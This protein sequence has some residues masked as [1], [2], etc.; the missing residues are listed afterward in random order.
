MPPQP[1]PDAPL[2]AAVPA[3]T[4]GT[5]P[6]LLGWAGD[7]G[8]WALATLDAQGRFS[9]LNEEA[10]RVLG[11]QAGELLGRG[12]WRLFA[13]T[14]RP[15]I[16][17][18]V[19]AA[20]AQR[21]PL[22]L[23]E[24]DER[25][26]RWLELRGQPFGAGLALHLRDVTTRRRSQEQLR[27][28]EGSISR[29]NDIV[30]IT[31]ASPFNEPG[32]RIV[33]VNE[34]FE[35]RTGYSREEALGRSPRFLQG[36]R[37][38]RDRLDQV[39]R[40]LEQWQPVRVD[41]VNYRKDGEPFWVDL[42]IS[43]VWDAARK[44][45]HW[46]A[47]GRDVSE[48]KAAEQKI[49]YLAFFDPLTGL[50]NRQQLMD[51]LQ[52]AAGP[53]GRAR[54]GA[55]MFIDL[56]NFKV[57]NDTL[58]H[59][60]GDL[61]LKEV[62]RRLGDCV[63]DDGLVARLG[64]DEFVVLLQPPA[65]D[66]QAAAAVA[67]GAARALAE[68][69]LAA[70]GEPYPLP[71]YLHHSTC[72]IGVTVFGPQPGPVSELLKQADLAMYQAKRAG[73]NTA[74]FFDPQMQAVASAHA[75]LAA[76]LR[77][78]CRE[79]RFHLD[80]QPQVDAR[81]YLRGVEALLRWDHPQRGCVPPERFIP[82]AEETS[83]ILDIG[84]QVLDAACAQ[85]ARWARRP[86]RE[87]LTVAVNVS[88][89]QFRHPE[90]VDGVM[91]AIARAGIAPHRLKLELTETLLADGFEV[92]VARMGELRSRGVALSLD[93]FG[94]GYSSLAYLKRLPL[95][96]LKIDRSFVRDVLSDPH[97][98]AIAR[99]II[100][101]AQSLGLDVLAEGV[102]TPAQRDFLLQQGCGAFQ[103]FLFAPALA[104]GPLEAWIDARHAGLAA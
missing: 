10:E 26:S 104:P 46:V 38:Q 66:P 67:A 7:A 54:G 58:G 80:Y 34:A 55:L 11:R 19:Q 83:L 74:C 41:L 91:D 36:P 78:A 70:L 44:L 77:Q 28:L 59:A 27:L 33:F 62:A 82:V 8:L 76:D 60:Q 22:E 96:Q 43:P 6:A 29:L 69:I 101:L 47:V 35:R 99:T 21:K 65:G 68:R 52:D 49:R 31:E 92:T 30:V 23:E 48:R 89:R 5:A 24:P 103:G 32:P 16:E 45:T 61:L 102:E 37:T 79:G 17:A 40:A 73:R 86:D 87:H 3:G 98:A 15:R 4:R 100:G 63:G 71:G 51:R 9:Y 93:D 20:L 18:Q 57:L 97:D 53:A 42:D 85:L 1:A 50:P 13:R 95:D 94:M 90:F 64:G 75:A 81:G 84:R 2:P 12:L 72:S 56:D 14:A 88:A 25:Q 39:R